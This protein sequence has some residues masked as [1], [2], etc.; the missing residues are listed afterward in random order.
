[1]G[2]FRRKASKPVMENRFRA[3]VEEAGNDHS[4]TPPREEPSG[5]NGNRQK[6]EERPSDIR[7]NPLLLIGTGRK[8]DQD[9]FP[10]RLIGLVLEGVLRGAVNEIGNDSF[11]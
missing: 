8:P 4:P 7:V 11:N 5:G 6:R 3:R 9:L 2:F 1:M 10:G